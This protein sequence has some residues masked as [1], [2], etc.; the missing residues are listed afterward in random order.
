MKEKSIE[1]HKLREEVERLAGEVEV[2]RG[3]VEEGL[4]ERRAV[5][6]G[7]EASNANVVVPEDSGEQGEVEE[8]QEEG[9]EEG[10]PEDD[11]PFDPLSILG[12]SRANIDSPPDKTMRTDH[13]TVGSSNLAAL[14]PRRFIENE[15][16]VRIS[17]E[18]NERRSDHSGSV[19]SQSR[20]RMGS[21]SPSPAR[22][23]K[24]T[25]E[26]VPEGNNGRRGNRAASPTRGPFQHTQTGTHQSHYLQPSTSRPAVPTQAHASGRR[27]NQ[28]GPS[29]L[30]TPF[31]QIR[32]AHL[33]RLFFSAPEHNAKTCTLCHRRR[34][35]GLSSPLPQ[36]SPSWPPSRANRNFRTR[37]EDARDDDDEGFVE[38][39]DEGPHERIQ[40]D[41]KGKGKQREHVMFSEDPGPRRNHVEREDGSLPPQTVLARV[42]KELEDDFTHYKR[43]VVLDFYPACDCSLP[44]VDLA[45]MSSW[46]INTRTWMRLR[47]F[48]SEIH[49]LHTSEKWLISW[50]KKSAL[51]L[52]QAFLSS[53]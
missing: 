22:Q 5:R 47:M 41:P 23:R 18:V 27:P 13:A 30:E 29:S 26:D 11:E 24:V 43:Y 42:I 8:T 53:Y 20:S 48:Q 1:V 7:A 31:P 33:E 49:L 52:P 44:H 51:L 14:T 46:L 17:A 3:V 35:P 16:L 21:R 2:L 10:E 36:S 50:N 9:G 38:G 12:S 37:M 39:S 4:R 15:E 45:S 19:L 25:V 6:D 32:G 28:T 40:S 34:R